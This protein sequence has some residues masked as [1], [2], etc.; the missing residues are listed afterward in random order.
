M[1]LV[2]DLTKFNFVGYIHDG[3]YTN[4]LRQKL[5]FVSQ[6]KDNFFALIPRLL[7]IEFL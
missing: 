1:I 2:I 4:K 5:S 7:K 3:K 6:G